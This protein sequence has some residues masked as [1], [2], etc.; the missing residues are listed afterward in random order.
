M[1]YCFV[2][3]TCGEVDMDWCVGDICSAIVYS[4]GAL[5]EVEHLVTQR[6]ATECGLC[7]TLGLLD[8]IPRELRRSRSPKEVREK[9]WSPEAP[10]SRVHKETASIHNPHKFEVNK[11]SEL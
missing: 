3:L 9:R 5:P 1:Y 11:E 2:F 7:L 6:F 8:H 4:R 10:A